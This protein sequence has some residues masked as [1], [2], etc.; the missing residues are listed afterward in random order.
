MGRRL[1]AP[2]RLPAGGGSPH[3][4]EPCGCPAEAL[5]GVRSVRVHNPSVGV[6]KI[7][8]LYTPSADCA[9]QVM[10]DDAPRM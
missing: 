7:D 5:W 8:R 1:R 6:S 10:C 3:A 9:V 4:P 2:R